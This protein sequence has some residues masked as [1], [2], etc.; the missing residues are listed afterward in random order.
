MEPIDNVSLRRLRDMMLLYLYEQGAGTPYWGASISDIK[1]AL[2]MGGREF[3]SAANLL[4]HQ[5]LLSRA[6]MGSLGLSLAGQHEAERLQPQVSFRDPQEQVSSRVTVGDNM[7]GI[8]QIG[9]SHS[10]QSA[11]VHI[12]LSSALQLVAEIELAVK[13]LE[14]APEKR[15]DAL[16]L[17]SSLQTGLR[18]RIGSA[19][20]KALATAL[21]GILKGAGSE[22]GKRLLEYLLTVA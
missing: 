5:G 2:N 12:D 14:L 22:A 16:E 8:I 13:E 11:A 1:K 21:D 15:A 7:Q 17:I 10:H 18:G 4:Q 3:A 19:A 20:N 9:A 6:P